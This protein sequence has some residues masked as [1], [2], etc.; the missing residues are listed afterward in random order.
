MLSDD[1]LLRLGFLI[2][3]PE[4]LDGIIAELSDERL[5]AILLLAADA[6]RW[7]EL[8]GMAEYLSE[9]QL[10]RVVELG[11]EL[12][13]EPALRAAAG[14]DPVVRAMAEPLLGRRAA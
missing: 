12:G 14:R 1:A 11:E 9:P 3:A 6:E 10:D 2:E 7:E 8:L 4:R 13:I 5:G